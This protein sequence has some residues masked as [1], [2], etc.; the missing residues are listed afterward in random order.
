MGKPP[1]IPSIPQENKI[2]GFFL[3]AFA[4]Q[5]KIPK[6]CKLLFNQIIAPEQYSRGENRAEP[7]QAATATSS[8]HQEQ[9]KLLAHKSCV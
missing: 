3:L 2:Q 8:Q 9:S 4:E 7:A 1:V 6:S 5:P